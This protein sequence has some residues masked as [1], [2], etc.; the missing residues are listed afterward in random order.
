MKT[1]CLYFYD[2]ENIS[3]TS[4][5]FNNE[6]DNIISQWTSSGYHISVFAFNP[7][8]THEQSILLL[9]LQSMN[10]FVMLRKKDKTVKL[11]KIPCFP[12]LGAVIGDNSFNLTDDFSNNII[13][14]RNKHN[15][16]SENLRNSI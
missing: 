8:S 5:H 6:L 12:G 2:G 9:N 14:F 3:A 4:K 7:I 11:K 16:I 15:V 10:T 1:L 13:K